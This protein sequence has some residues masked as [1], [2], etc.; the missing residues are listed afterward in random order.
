[1]TPFELFIQST[2]VLGQ[3][4]NKLSTQEGKKQFRENFGSFVKEVVTFQSNKEHMG[5]TPLIGFGNL[6]LLIFAQ[7]CAYIVNG[8][9]FNTMHVILACLCSPLYLIWVLIS[10][11]II[12]QKKV[13][14]TV[15]QVAPEPVE[16]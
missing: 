2:G 4:A 12:L 5:A 13:A 15:N 6:V 7:L 16:N 10:Y 8:N 14:Q 11:N 1:M 3:V 9:Q